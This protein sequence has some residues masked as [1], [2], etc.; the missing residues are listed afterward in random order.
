MAGKMEV[1]A[2]S[3]CAMAAADRS[4]ERVEESDEQPSAGV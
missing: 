4:A 3:T 2:R 1:E